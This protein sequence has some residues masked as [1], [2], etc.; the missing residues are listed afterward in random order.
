[1]SRL[2]E[3]AFEDRD[4]VRIAALSGELD[5]SNVRD[6][7]DALAAAVPADSLG[8]VI[9]MTELR[10]LDSAGLRM[11]FDLRRRLGQRRQEVVLAVPAQAR[12]R[13]VLELGAVELTIVVLPAVDD[14]IAAVRESARA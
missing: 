2:A 5:L 8:L 10:H 7:S 13:D 4:S 14:A 9:D 11:L 6:V 1:V 3:L 12:V